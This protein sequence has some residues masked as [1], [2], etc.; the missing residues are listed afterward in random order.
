MLNRTF[1]ALDTLGFPSYLCAHLLSGLG[2]SMNVIALSL[3]LFQLTG[4]VAALAGMWAARVAARLLLQP[5]L[6][7]TVDRC[8]KKRL[9]VLT[10]LGNAGV[11]AAFLFVNGETLWL[12]LALTFALQCLDGLAGPA[13][14]AAVP[15]LLPREQLA[16]GNALLSLTGKVAGSLGPALAGV[17][18][19]AWGAAPLFAFNAVSFVLLAAVIARL[20]FLAPARPAQAVTFWQDFRTGWRVALGHPLVLTVLGVSLV[21]NAAW[22]ALEITLVPWAQALNA[23]G[24]SAYGMLFTALT[25]GGV[26]GAALVPHLHL[27]DRPFR[28]LLWSF[29]LSGVPLAALGLGHSAPLA[30]AAMFVCG[31]LLDVVGITTTTTLQRSVPGEVLGRVFAAVNVSAAL[32]ALPV[33]AGLAGLTGWVGEAGVIVGAGLLCT[34]A[35]LG[36]GGRWAHRRDLSKAPLIAG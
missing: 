4:S 24:V 22:R 31:A 8:D 1:P 19:A 12:A 17:L 6:G 16:S 36:L 11:A 2:N 13:L 21:S 33:L 9:L 27:E 20:T 26:A 15:G 34:A 10:H 32:G 3:L 18:F 5:V 28:K 14:G 7:V 35:A 29:G 25:L 30:L 23:A